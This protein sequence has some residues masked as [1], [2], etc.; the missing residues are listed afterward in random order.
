MSSLISQ[1][2]VETEA[3]TGCTFTCFCDTVFHMFSCSQIDWQPF[4]LHQLQKF[5]PFDWLIEIYLQTEGQVTHHKMAPTNAWFFPSVQM[6]AME[7]PICIACL[8]RFKV[9]AVAMQPYFHHI[10]HL[11]KVTVGRRACS[12]G[13]QCKMAG[14]CQSVC[15]SF[16]RT[17]AFYNLMKVSDE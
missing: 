9:V 15:F 10:Q 1:N 14:V 8:V 7:N 17:C 11:N 3:V 12:V 13:Q 4:Y 16:D 5:H 2:L 6:V